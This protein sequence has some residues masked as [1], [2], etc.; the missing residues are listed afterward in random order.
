MDDASLIKI[1]GFQWHADSG[2]PRC[3]CFQVE[4]DKYLSAA[5]SL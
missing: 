4:N 3:N 2:D 5:Y 1:L